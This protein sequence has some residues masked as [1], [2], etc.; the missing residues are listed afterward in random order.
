MK[1]LLFFFLKKWMQMQKL[2]DCPHTDAMMQWI[3]AAIQDE[4]QQQAL[5]FKK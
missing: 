2:G 5:P 1:Q 4:N 3:S